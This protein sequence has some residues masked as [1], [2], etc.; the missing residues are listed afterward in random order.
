MTDARVGFVRDRSVSSVTSR[1][2]KLIL[3]EVRVEEVLGMW[4][5]DG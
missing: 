5:D 4:R 1:I 3:L 2:S